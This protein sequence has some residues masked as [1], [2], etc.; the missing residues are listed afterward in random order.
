MA[1]E[2]QI[3]CEVQESGPDTMQWA[4]RIVRKIIS[5]YGKAQ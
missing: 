1:A 4:E 3:N 2:K 5:V